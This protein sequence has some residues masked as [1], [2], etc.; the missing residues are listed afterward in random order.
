MAKITRYLVQN[1]IYVSP[2]NFMCE[3]KVN[4]V[5]LV[6]VS[7]GAEKK[8]GS[9]KSIHRFLSSKTLKPTPTPRLELLSYYTARSAMD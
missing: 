7:V 8:R 3:A 6:T 9:Y 2:R 1:V 4:D 5:N